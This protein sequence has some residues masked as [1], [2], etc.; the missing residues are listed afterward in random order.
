[1][2]HHD[3]LDRMLTRWTDDPGFVPAPPYLGAVLERTRHTRQ[4]TA[5]A[6][7]ERWL[8][9]ATKISG[10][11]ATLPLRMAWLLIIGLIVLAIVT[12]L[13]IV[14]SRFL[15]QPVEIPQGGA[16]VYVFASYAGGLGSQTDGEI[17]TVRAD[18]TDLR[19]LTSGPGTRSA[20]AFS[21]DGTHIAYHSWRAGN[22][23][24]VIADAGGGN[25]VTVATTPAT[26][27]F[28][29]L[30]DLAWSPDGRS[31]IFPANANCS[32]ANDLYIVPSDGSAPA[33]KLIAGQMFGLGASWSPDAK[34]IAFVGSDNGIDTG[35]YVADV[36]TDGGRSGALT[37]RRV[38]PG[39]LGGISQVKS[40]PRWSPDSNELLTT[41]EK[42]NVVILKADGSG[43]RVV[44]TKSTDKEIENAPPWGPAWA[45]AWS[46]D[47][48]RIAY[49]RVVDRAER[50]QDRGCSV[51]AWVVNADGTGE[52]RLEPLADQCDWPLRWSPDGTRLAMLLV[53]P[54]PP[55]PDH[56]FH[57][58]MVTV[59]GSEPV[60]TLS[61][62]TDGSWQPVVAALPPA[63]SFATGSS[64]P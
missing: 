27:A 48:R 2:T 12:T 20:P 54:T 50:F 7:L 43:Q 18:G 19:Q 13:A 64:T 37:A 45:P 9:M 11:T 49:V 36:G 32:D 59:D 41:N 17:F 38:G 58:S 24:L 6:N 61:D 5:W 30:G 10:Q 42:G 52:K 57:L 1:M 8:P 14:G 60:V 46:P 53:D 4:R 44:G 47:G 22:N 40:G 55:D 28:C 34:R 15:R 63:P 26:D 62:S 35:T 31:V 29:P 39:P 56:A 51:R 25:P 33:V 23:S 16:A 3:D 21:P